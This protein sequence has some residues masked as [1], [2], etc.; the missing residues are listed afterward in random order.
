[1]STATYLRTRVDRAPIVPALLAGDVA[2]ILL[3]VGIGI[4]SHGGDPIGEP[5][6][7]VL[8]AAPFLLSWLLVAVIG[9]LY[10]TDAVIDPRRALS[11]TVPAWILAALLGQGLRATSLFP[12]DTALTFAI[13]SI[14]AGGALVA[15]WRLGITLALR[16]T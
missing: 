9:G 2:A 15:G 1:M 4:N 12:G 8:T 7:L 10:T 6:H 16:V 14:V 3:F 13:V 11:W 5:G